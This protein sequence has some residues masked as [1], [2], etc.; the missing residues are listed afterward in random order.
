MSRA[1]K[2]AGWSLPSI[3]LLLLKPILER[4][5]RGGRGGAPGECVSLCTHIIDSQ[6]W[7]TNYSFRLN[8]SLLCIL[9][10]NSPLFP[11]CVLEKHK[12]KCV[13]RLCFWLSPAVCLSPLFFFFLLRKTES[14]LCEKKLLLNCNTY[15]YFDYFLKLIYFNWRL[16][17]LQYWGGF[18]HTLTWIGH[19]CSYVPHPEAPSRLPPHPIPLVVPV[20]PLWVPCFMHWAWTG[21]LFHIW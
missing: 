10:A 17:I 21:D 1:Y 4:E 8:A 14:L 3:C 2:A 5:G 9:F 11:S 12:T 13:H 16:I 7:Q 19:G 20:H 15:T 18:C 6:R